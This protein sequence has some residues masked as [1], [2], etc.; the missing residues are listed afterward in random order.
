M[1]TTFMW[2]APLGSFGLPNQ[3]MFDHIGK[4]HKLFVRFE[5]TLVDQ[6]SSGGGRRSS[7]G[8]AYGEAPSGIEGACGRGD[9]E[10]L[11]GPV[12]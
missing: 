12:G 9:G 8:L 11:L 3:P 4:M 10:E 6:A 7:C 1:P 2:S 5:S